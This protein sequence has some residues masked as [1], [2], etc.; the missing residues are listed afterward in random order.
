VDRLQA[1]GLVERHR[2]PTDRRSYALEPTDHGRQTLTQARRAIDD[3]ARRLD[4]TLGGAEQRQEL[5]RLLRMLLQR[6]EAD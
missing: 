5:N 6:R 1:A 4:D 2:D 3:L